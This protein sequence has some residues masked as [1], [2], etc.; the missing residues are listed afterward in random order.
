MQ[1]GKK[2]DQ[3]HTDRKNMHIRSIGTRINPGI[4]RQEQEAYQQHREAK[5]N[6]LEGEHTRRIQ[7]KHIELFE[8]FGE[9]GGRAPIHFPDV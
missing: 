7:S 5:R 3:Q 1:R 2:S 9:N 6:I 8:A 4:D